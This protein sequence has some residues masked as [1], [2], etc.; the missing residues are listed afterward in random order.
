MPKMPTIPRNIRDSKHKSAKAFHQ[1]QKETPMTEA[2]IEEIV[3]AIIET[4]N[5]CN[6]LEDD[7]ADWVTVG[8]V[9]VLIADWRAKKA[10]IERLRTGVVS[11]CHAAA[12][13]MR[14][15][16]HEL[17]EKMWPEADD[18]LDAIAAL[19]QP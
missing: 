7:R 12:E 3:A 16:C 10:E 8:E 6:F 18:L 4:L 5:D 2:R 14:A 9:R 11:G 19:K 1:S 13:A 17:V 15:K